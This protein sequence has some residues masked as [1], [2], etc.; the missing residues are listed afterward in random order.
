MEHY[1]R[2]Q[3][4]EAAR[5][6]IAAIR[7]SSKGSVLSLSADLSAI[8]HIVV[9]LKPAILHLGASTDLLIPEHVRQLKKKFPWLF[10]ERSIPVVDDNCIYIAQSYD[11]IADMLLLDSHKPGDTKSGRLV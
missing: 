9:S 10:V 11:G 3:S 8:E 2:E 6:V 5:R 4:I 1:P 7:P